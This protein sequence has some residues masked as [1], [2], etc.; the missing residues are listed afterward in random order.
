MTTLNFN[1]N[2]EYANALQDLADSEE[3]VSKKLEGNTVLQA[4]KL[5]CL[6][7][8]RYQ[9]YHSWWQHSHSLPFTFNSL[10]KCLYL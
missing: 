8:W 10:K 3:R 5:V 6:S 4:A 9:S 7:H 2:K 1:F